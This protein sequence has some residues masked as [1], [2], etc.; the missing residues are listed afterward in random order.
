MGRKEPEEEMGL[1]VLDWGVHEGVLRN[2][3]DGE[4]WREVALGTKG[5]EVERLWDGGIGLEVERLRLQ[6]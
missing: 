6:G 4:G 5:G 2:G 1:E 3:G